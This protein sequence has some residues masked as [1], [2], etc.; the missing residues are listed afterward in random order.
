VAYDR[1]W[2]FVPWHK[3]CPLPCRESA[4]RSTDP[5][6]SA[7]VQLPGHLKAC[8]E[9]GRSPSGDRPMKNFAEFQILGNIGSTK[10]VGNTVRIQVCANYAEK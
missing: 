4:L 10:E 8:V 2:T 7:P 1:R 5:K 3:N 6:G 9:T